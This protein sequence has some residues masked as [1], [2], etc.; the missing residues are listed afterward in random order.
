MREAVLVAPQSHP[1]G[2]AA[3]PLCRAEVWALMPSHREPPSRE[4]LRAA[5]AHVQGLLI[6]D[7]GSLDADARELIGL[8]AEERVD[9]LRL[10]PNRG[11]GGALR[12]GVRRLLAQRAPP[13]AVLVIDADGQHPPEFIPAFL[14]ASAYAEL[15]IGDRLGDPRSMPQLRRTGNLLSRWLLSALTGRPVGDTQSGMRLLHGRAL[16]ELEIPEGGYEAETRHLRRVLAR[17]ISVAWIP[18]PAIYG[19]EKSSFGMLRDT[20]R[21]LSALLERSQEQ[22][23]SPLPQRPR[24]PLRRGRQTGSGLRGRR[25]RTQQSPPERATAG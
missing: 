18:I 11:K 8:A 10:E 13:R 6:V 19:N 9:L 15:V 2:D 25:A 16:H 20:F 3:A 14:A 24:A 4:L 7:D 22:P 12:A 23:Q 1:L 21:V 17:G 5:R